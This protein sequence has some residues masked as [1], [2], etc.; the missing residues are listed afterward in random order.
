MIPLRAESASYT[1]MRAKWKERI[2]T[3]HAAIHPE[4]I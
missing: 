2:G 3:K 1:F 4:F